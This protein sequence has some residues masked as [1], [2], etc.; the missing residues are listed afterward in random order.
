MKRI[1][2][3]SILLFGTILV[4][5][6]QTTQV[7]KADKKYDDFYYIDA[8]KTYE[9]V[10]NRGYKSADMLEK[11]GNAYYF[12]AQYE[13]AAKWYGELFA[14][15][16][17]ASNPEYYHRYSLSLKSIGEYD[18]A[19]E[20]L[21]KYYSERGEAKPE[22]RSYLEIIDMNSGRY[23]IENAADLN[24]ELSD[25]GTSFYEGSIIFAS[26][27]RVSRMVSRVMGWNE[28]PHSILYTAKVNSEGGFD[29]AEIFSDK[30]DSKFNESTAV[31]TKDGK[32][33]Y[34]TR[35]NYLKKRGYSDDNTTFLKVYRATLTNNEWGNI[36][37]LPFNDDNYN[38]A[39]PA[40]SSDEKTLYFVSDMPGTLGDADIWKV[41]ILG[42]D[43]YGIPINL[44]PTIN[45]EGR[46]SFPF[47]TENELY[48]ASTGKLGLG[49]LDIFISRITEDGEY[50]EAINVGKP[51]NSPMDDFA[52]YIHSETREGFFS[53]NREGGKGDDDI[54]KLIEIRELICEQAIVG[55]ITDMDSGKPLTE[56]K[57]I[58]S[59]ESGNI[60]AETYTNLE[61]KYSFAKESARCDTPYRIKAEQEDYSIEEEFIRTSKNQ[62]EKS[63]VDIVLKKVKEE[64]IVGKT[65]NEVLNIPII[66]FDLDKW[67][68]R[69]DAEVEIVKVLQVLEDYPQMKVE[70]GSHTDSRASH[71]YNQRLSE[72]RAA[73]TRDWLVSNGVDPVR[74][75]AV[76]YGETQ[77]VNDCA[78]G[79]DCTE[80]QHQ[81]NR[82]STFT[83]TSMGE[84]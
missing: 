11:L 16:Q 52:F 18:K 72:R 74:L 39:H 53:S 24:S 27:R 47:V 69:P 55:T 80:D 29:K 23:D 36:I 65:L 50:E 82:R 63:Q 70:I 20:Y 17:K 60:L 48:Y 33:I 31:F 14:F 30:L 22:I 25:Y 68:I 26:T 19:N 42:E 71:A 46:E 38:I 40:L 3:M 73:S 54:Y 77:L 78:D 58:L 15:K 59:D 1:L 56:A 61:G 10:V 8:I 66:Y 4:S 13:E 7:K 49:G 12:N 9:K 21:N 44:G 75:T 2:Y 43:N 28:Q 35:N 51:I 62:G 84:E 83:I 79:V 67:D 45:T 34:F 81:L 64:P 76:G 6:A 5:E 32:T 37:E 41:D 57:I